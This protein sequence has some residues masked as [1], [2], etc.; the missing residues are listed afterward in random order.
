[1]GS[2]ALLKHGALAGV[3]LVLMLA[4]YKALPSDKCD[5]SVLTVQSQNA[6]IP[7]NV[8]VADTESLR[9]KGL[10]YVDQLPQSEGLLF[11]YPSPSKRY[12]WM[13]NT[14]IELDI[15]FADQTGRVRFI[16]E[17]AVPLDETPIYGGDEIQF[18][19][20]LNGGLS[21]RYGIEVGAMLHHPGIPSSVHSCPKERQDQG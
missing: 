8:T 20:E 17:N 13:K 4:P 11:V 2:A 18:V 12:F 21:D 7:F 6:T 9:A 19:L 14:L 5:P 16:Y 10:M 15:L 1:M 3:A